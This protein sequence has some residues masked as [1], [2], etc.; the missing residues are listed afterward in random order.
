M[1][2]AGVHA[3]FFSNSLDYTRGL[4]DFPPQRWTRQIMLLKGQTGAGPNYFVFRDDFEPLPD[5]TEPLQQ[6]WWYLKNPGPA[7]TVSRDEHGL[8]FTSHFGPRLT[9]RIL[10]PAE[11]ALETREAADWQRHVAHANPELHLFQVTALGPNPPGQPVLAALYPRSPEEP[12]PVCER[13][14]ANAAKITTPEGTD[15]VFLDRRPLQFRDGDVAFAGTAGAIR[16][17]GETVEFILAEGPGRLAYRGFE[18]RGEAPG[19]CAVPL[20]KI[21]PGQGATLARLR[22]GLGLDVPRLTR[23]V[24]WQ[25]GVT[26]GDFPNGF[27]LVVDSPAPVQVEREGVSFRGRKGGV[28]VDR[29][30]ATVRI[31]MLDGD[32]AGYRETRAWAYAQSGAYDLT[33]YPDRIVGKSAGGGRLLYLTMPPGLYRHITLVVDG[34]TFAP[35]TH[36]RTVIVPLM[37]GEHTWAVRDLEQP[38]VFR[39]WQGW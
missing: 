26:R 2:T 15:Y 31:I 7:E 21:S 29:K 28:I 4:G 24:E 38:A 14:A 12:S 16:V 27:A 5:A 1:P 3:H 11:A 18:V 19:V 35:G 32:R 25:P 22:H 33:V 36:E 6:S 17:H 30:A 23:T 34:Q 37:P 13:L 10:E 39:N 20:S 9:V 8:E